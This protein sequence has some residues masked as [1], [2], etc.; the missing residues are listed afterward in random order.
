MIDKTAYVHPSSIVEDGAVIG[1][2]VRI[3][4]FA[5]LALMLKLVKVLS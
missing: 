5:I 3:G 2:N 1:A 4:P